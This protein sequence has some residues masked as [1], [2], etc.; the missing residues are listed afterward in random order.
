MKQA[1]KYKVEEISKFE[2]S[3][4]LLEKPK[5]QQLAEKSVKEEQMYIGGNNKNI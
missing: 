3:G 2:I 1:K 4:Q 5:M